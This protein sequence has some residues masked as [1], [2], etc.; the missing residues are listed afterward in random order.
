MP[1]PPTVGTQLR[2]ARLR[3]GRTLRDLAKVLGLSKG[4]ISGV[5]TGTTRPLRTFRLLLW[6]DE[7]GLNGEELAIQAWAEKAP[8]EI[9]NLVMARLYQ[10]G[11]SERQARAE[12][13]ERARHRQAVR[14]HLEKALRDLSKVLKDLTD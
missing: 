5:E 4:C 2:A 10:K 8:R 14:S 13:H 12:A 11:A 3:Q 6:A 9:R 7:V 1:I